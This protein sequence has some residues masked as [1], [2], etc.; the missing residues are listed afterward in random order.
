MEK[1]TIEHLS[2][3]FPYNLRMWDV[4]NERQYIPELIGIV[5]SEKIRVTLPR[6]PGVTLFEINALKPIL[7]PIQ[8]VE[9]YFENLYGYLEHQDVTDYFDVDF[10]KSHDNIE[11]DEIQFLKVEELP[12]GT[13]KVLLKHHFDVFGLI[14]KGLAIP[15]TNELNPY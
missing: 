3:Y 2:P 6:F 14:E 7:R 1:L 4:E 12:F 8:E 9:Q 15:V 13:L 11:I 5:D 10:L